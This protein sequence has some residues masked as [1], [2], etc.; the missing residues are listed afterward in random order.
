MMT[1]LLAASLN[2]STM[3]RYRG[4]PFAPGSFVRSS[5]QIRFTLFGMTAMRCFAILH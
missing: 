1:G 5:T 2:A 4:S 3:S